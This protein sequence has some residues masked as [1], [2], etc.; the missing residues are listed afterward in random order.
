MPSTR[1]YPALANLLGGYFHQD[2]DVV[3]EDDEGLIHEY[4]K[5]AT[6]EQN[7][8]LIDDIERFLANHRTPFAAFEAYFSPEAM[9]YE[10][11]D[12]GVTEWLE[13]VREML[14]E[15]SL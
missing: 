11:S 10:A 15:A 7:T 12:E 9:F 14:N 3:A 13:A 2:F 6:P 4:L 5:H 8:A 1:D